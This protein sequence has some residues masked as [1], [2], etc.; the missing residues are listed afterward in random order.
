MSVGD[1]VKGKPLSLIPIKSAFPP[2]KLLELKVNL[3][4]PSE[5]TLLRLDAYLNAPPSFS[6]AE[7]PKC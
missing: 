5:A 6:T 3:L 7:K 1:T 4:V 2:S